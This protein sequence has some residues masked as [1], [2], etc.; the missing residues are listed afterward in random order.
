MSINKFTTLLD[1][2]RQAKIITGETATFDGKIEVGIPF[3]GYPTGV[4]TGT[5]V[6]LGIVSSQECIFSGDISTTLFD[7]SNISSPNYSSIF[8]GYTA[9]TWTDPI[10]SAYTSGLTLPVTAVSASTQIVGTFWTLTETGYTGDYII[11]TQYTGF[12]VT[13]SFNNVAQFGT[14]DTFSGVTT[15]IQENFS[16][17]TLDYK[18]PLDYLQSVEDATIDGRLYT[19][20]ITISDG[21]S[22]ATTNYVLTQTDDTGKGEWNSI[23]SL[24]SGTCHPFINLE[25]ISGCSISGLT[26]DSD[27]TVNGDVTINGS[28]TTINTE[29]IQS[30]D[31]NIVLNYSGTHITAIGG[32][33]TLEDGVS[34]GVDSKIYSNSDGVWLFNP[35]LSATSLS[36]ITIGSSGNCVTDLYTSKIHSCS[37]L[38]INELDEGDVTIG[39]NNK[40]YFDVTNGW[41]GI[42][43]VP[44][45]GV[46][47][48]TQQYGNF[49]FRPTINATSVT[50]SGISTNVQ[51][52]SVQN[53]T[54][55][56]FLGQIG[57]NCTLLPTFGDQNDS[58]LD[59]SAANNLNIITRSGTT[60]EKSI[61]FYVGSDFTSVP[62]MIIKGS[63]STKGYVGIN[64]LNPQYQLDIVNIQSRLYYDP[65]SSGGRLN[66]SG[67]TG[68]PRFD[69]SI[70][71]Y[72]TKPTTGGSLGIRTWDNV[73]SPGYGKVGDMHLYAG[74]QIN[75][76]NIINRGPG[77]TTEDYIRFYAGQDANGT[78]A[79]I[80]IA[81][82]GSTRGYVGIGTET[83]DSLL[84]VNGKTKTTQFQMTSG[85]TNGY[86]LTSD[87]SGNA[88]WQLS[89]GGGSFTGGTV[90]GS[91]TFSGGISATTISA[92]TIGSSG[93]CVDDIYVTNLRSCSPLNINS[94][95]EGSVYFGSTSGVTIDVINKR[96][97]I[98]TNPSVELD[99]KGSTFL[100]GSGTNILSVIGSG[101]STTDPIVGI[102]GSSGELFTIKD[103]LV[104]SLFSVND[105]SGIPT[106]EVFDNNTVLMGS[107]SAPAMYTT[108][109]FQP[110]TGLTNLYSIDM[111]G[112]TGAWFDYTVVNSTTVGA[113][114]GQI[115]AI[116]S[117]N[118]VNY[119]ETTTS[120]IGSTSAITLSLSANSVDCVLQSSA[121]TLGWEVKTIIR[122]I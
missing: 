27:V 58:F 98:N 18:G 19:N 74:D 91:T 65:T 101:S 42:G 30:K 13:Y 47:D 89:T 25:V 73:T 99:I 52:V 84:T 34:N 1:L 85:A 67:S 60:G 16:A 37:P 55:S 82:S 110:I 29:V 95:D 118:T 11:G 80:H 12:S 90:T 39:T 17:G 81:G 10:F 33:I 88:S 57:P 20:K 117:G 87:G 106:L 75:G 46:I 116:F 114:S 105:I 111:S 7:V 93:D 44:T 43:K 31:N 72:L 50:I 45:L 4:D 102:S 59:S 32:G 78:I 3:S 66:I 103:S 56:L 113:R 2:S 115:M 62:N 92:T 24:L 108:V 9:T 54:S 53:G 96:I 28:A 49:I 40:F 109:K 36:A 104:G 77:T 61:K 83:P 64:T 8:S 79:D 119:V 22:S 38:T 112:Y 63:G 71:A 35:S 122:S 5:T 48:V 21:A 86:V 51:Q 68:L 121:T 23:S 94:L 14:G 15:A 120:S 26:I 100:S 69:V 97:G 107:Y 70:P 41:L 6:S 76:L